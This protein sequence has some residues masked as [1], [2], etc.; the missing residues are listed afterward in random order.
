MIALFY[1]KRVTLL[2]CVIVFACALLLARLYNLAKPETNK[3]MEVLTGQYTARLDVCERNGFVY[4]TNGLLLSHEKSG[5]AAIVN[6]GE[7]V[8]A[9]GCAYAL[10]EYAVSDSASDIFEKIIDGV[11]FTVSIARDSV[12]GGLPSVYVFDKYEERNDIAKHFL[13]YN[14]ERGGVSGL[15]LFYD[16]YLN[17]SEH[18]KVSVSFD[19]NAKRMSL[20][21]FVTECQGYLS[22]DGLVTS[23]DRGLQT[24]CDSLEEEIGSGAVVVSD[25]DTGY[26][27]A[28]SSFPGYDVSNLSDILLSDKGELVNR[29]LQSFTPGSVF[30]MIVAASALEKDRALWD[31]CY[32]CNGKIEIDG[33]VFRCHKLSGHGEMTMKDAFANSCNTYFISLGREIGIEKVAQTM[34][35]LR[36]DEKT[37]ADFLVE[38]DSYFV[39]TDNKREGYLANISFGQG[40]LCLSPLDMIK[41]TNALSTGYLTPLSVIRGKIESGVFGGEKEIIRERIFSEETVGKMLLM[42]KECVESGTGSGAKTKSLTTGGKTATA[43]TGRFDEDGVEYVHKWFCG[44]APIEKPK[45]SI[46]V[47]CDFSTNPDVSPSVIFSK[48]CAYLQEN[49][50]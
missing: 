45:Y 31:F 46:L 30:K 27:L 26:I 18:H 35:K 17:K 39:D 36:L 33:N 23:I 49:V 34:K 8:D 16:E 4:D 21:S 41:V 14:A 9:L 37:R 25:V 5:K 24:F 50:F 12:V 42:M 3:S 44:V 10:S 29:V 15:R 43:Q 13:G 22:C 20:S 2:Y 48:I 7:C 28:L 38:P 6:P 32:T 40:D 47:L 11:P 19:T 1:E